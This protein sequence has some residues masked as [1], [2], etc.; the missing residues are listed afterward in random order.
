MND[1]NLDGKYQVTSTSNYDGPLERKSDGITIIRNGETA[2]FDE[3]NV[4]WSSRFRVLNEKEVEMTAIADPAEAK[5]GFALTR[6]DGSPTLEPVTY[7]TILRLA[8]KEGKI[9][10]S[11]QIEYGDEIVLLTMR[12]LSD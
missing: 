8:R 1:I 2:R 7:K 9:Q 10:M 3:N 12:R 6:P 5:E 11:G 4:L